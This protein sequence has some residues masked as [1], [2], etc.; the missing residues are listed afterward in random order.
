MIIDDT[1]GYIFDAKIDCNQ[2]YGLIDSIKISQTKNKRQIKL[3]MGVDTNGNIVPP[4]YFDLS[5]GFT[6]VSKSD[7]SNYI[8]GNKSFFSVVGEFALI[9]HGTV[10]I[11]VNT[12]QIISTDNV[13]FYAPNTILNSYKER[14]NANGEIL[15]VIVCDKVSVDTNEINTFAV[16]PELLNSYITHALSNINLDTTVSK[17]TLLES[18]I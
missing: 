10:T 3:T 12:N 16:Q 5:L 18:I 11:D 15:P 2:Q 8:R 4:T 1:L 17:Q 14:K 9:L 6:K 13:N 7:L